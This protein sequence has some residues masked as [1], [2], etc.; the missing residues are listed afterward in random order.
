MRS[1][2][3]FGLMLG[4]GLAASCGGER[5]SNFASANGGRGGSSQGGSAGTMGDG[6]ADD[7]AGTA[8]Q[9]QTGGMSGAAG[10]RS[11]AAGDDSGMA[12][13][14]GAAGDTSAA[15]GDGG[16]AGSSGG[17]CGDGNLDVTLLEECD[18]GGTAA[19]DGCDS[20]CQLEPVGGVMCGNSNLDNLE[21]CDPP[22]AMPA[23]GDGCNATCNLSGQVTTL[24]T[25]INAGALTSDNDSLYLAIS[26]C[27]ADVCGI[28]RIDIAACN[29]APGTA[30]C[31]PQFI[32]GG[33]GQCACSTGTCPSV[34]PAAAVVDGDKDTATFGDMSSMATDGTTIWVSHQQVLREIDVATGQVTTVAGTKGSCAAIDGNGTNGLMH[35]VRGLTYFGGLVYMLDSCE[36][37]LRAYDPASGDL[38]TLAGTRDP[39]S[40]VTQT[41][42]YTCAAACNFN[43]CNGEPA[44]PV[45]GTG[46]S[47]VM[48][49]PRYMT[50]DS[51]GM[52]YIIDTNGEA[53][54]SYDTTS[55][56]VEI[57]ISGI[58]TL[59][60][61]YVD[62]DAASATIGRPRGIVSDGSSV[63]FGEQNYAT[64]R[65]L[66]LSNVTT[67][68]FVGT[69]GCF[70][71][72]SEQPRDGLG[73]NTTGVFWNNNDCNNPP[74]SPVTPI[75]HTLLGAMTFNF[76]SK[77]IYLIDTPHLR[78]IE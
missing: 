48:V 62:G 42:P 24:N 75:F 51:A 31:Q 52:L 53:I 32:S 6:G 60:N 9:S 15:A 64:V 56:E 19:G 8:G 26:D 74:N 55:T 40:Q 47:A 22:E 57:L 68:T 44:A 29:A 67:T 3:G 25:N 50:P 36:R 33:A 2:L 69:Q 17:K 46:T 72:G 1:R 37:V 27:T 58:D 77:S 41:A 11:G 78:R 34:T 12:G 70:A 59:P 38:T 4:F 61:P 16:A 45:A 7:G 39:D 76:A 20:S 23:D 71:G 13:G 18:D 66:E 73:A 65:Q 10:D 43:V 49:S 14:G 63:Y 54:L 30:A 5:S 21:K 35:S 28:A